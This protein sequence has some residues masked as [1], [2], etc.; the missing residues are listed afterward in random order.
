MDSNPASSS[1]RTGLGEYI[2]ENREDLEEIAQGEY[3]I[4]P[5]VQALLDRYDRGDI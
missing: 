5:V 2:D 1:S 3:P 4:S